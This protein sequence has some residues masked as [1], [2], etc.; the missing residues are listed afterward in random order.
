MTPK[1]ESSRHSARHAHIVVA[2]TF[3]AL[4]LSAGILST[5]GVLMV[6]LGLSFGWDRSVVSTGAA[7]GI[8]LY[9]LVG[10]FAAALM[11]S[12]GI[13]RTMMSGLLLIGAATLASLWMK[14]PWQYIVTWGVLSG[15]GSGALAGVLGAAVVNRWFATRQGLMIGIL[16]A[17]TAT[18]SLI[19]LPFLA[20]LSRNAQWQPVA[21]AVSIAALALV[22][23]VY[24]LVPEHPHH[25]GVRRVGETDMSP[26]PPAPH[27]ART[28][29]AAIHVLQKASKVPAFWLLA[30]TF[31]A[32]GLTTNGLVGTHLIAY[33]GDHGIP[34][35]HAAGFMSMIGLFDLIGTTASGWLTDRY[36][37]RRL[38]IGFYAL[39]GVS[40]LIMPFVDFSTTNLTIFA[41]FFGLDWIATI[42]PTL[43]LANE[44]FGEH[45]APIVFGWVVVAHQLGA[46]GAAIGAGTV[47]QM[48]G[49]YQPAFVA[50]GV[51]ALGAA[52][53]LVVSSIRHT[54]RG[55]V[56]QPA[57]AQ[58]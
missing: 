17:S 7:T 31:F 47:R 8:F 4:L 1:P 50:A 26:P 20:W 41:V 15:I 52:T 29:M 49:S 53:V 38:L 45:D 9:G 19:F 5:P 2:I 21:I 24:F 43:K 54:R 23:L 48:A 12:F 6:P 46:A 27:Q 22:P 40:L 57:R 34:P 44:A 14:E 28:P 37:S 11:L 42:P 18:G 16:S 13:R 3:F 33:C 35:V 36:D 30:G 55:G 51:I 58:S 32:C 10:P 56:P 39:R 25:V